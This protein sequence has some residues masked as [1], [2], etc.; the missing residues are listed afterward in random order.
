MAGRRSG[1]SSYEDMYSSADYGIETPPVQKKAPEKDS[2]FY[3]EMLIGG[4]VAGVLSCVIVQQLFQRYY[5][6]WPNLILVGVSIAVTTFLLVLCCGVVESF[7]MGI[8]GHS[9]GVSLLKTLVFALAGSLVVGAAAVGLEFLYELG[10]E[11]SGVNYD[12]YIFVVD[13]SGSMSG[14]D[15]R[16][17]RYS[18]LTQLL[19][20]MDDSNQVGIIRFS[21]GID[22]EIEPAVVDSDHK[23]ALTDFISQQIAYGGGTDIALGL[24]RAYEMY[25]DNQRAGFDSAVV[26]LS[27]GQSY[28]DA[29]ALVD[30]FNGIDVD[31]CTVALGSGA[32]RRMLSRLA[33]GT[34]GMALEVSDA[35]AIRASYALISGIGLKRCLL[36]P[37]I[38]TDRTNILHAVMCVVFLTLLGIG[39]MLVLQM[40]FNSYY[41]QPQLLVGTAASLLGS[42][43]LEIGHDLG[44]GSVVRHILLVLYCLV[45]IR[46]GVRSQSTL[47]REDYRT[48]GGAGYRDPDYSTSHVLTRDYADTDT[49]R[50]RGR[51]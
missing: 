22:D 5:M 45:L 41:M 29:D 36:M 31:I 42:L 43:I 33:D 46:C 20:R 7:K 30:L 37:R 28:V 16:D 3:V 13:D 8:S 1:G 35:D 50:G 18:A 11:Q 38:G 51:R 10:F 17:Q 24:Q 40:M 14:N 48:S 25:Q 34:G 12:D 6:S 21:S 19:D 4:L 2:R 27:D 23:D 39:M 9:G 47:E 15:P 44:A 26:L 32:D 49:G